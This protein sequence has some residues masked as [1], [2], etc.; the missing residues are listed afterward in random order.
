MLSGSRTRAG[1]LAKDLQEHEL[2]AFTV[3][4]MTGDLNQGRL[5]GSMAMQKGFEYPL[6]KFAVITETIFSDRS[7]KKEKKKSTTASGFRIL[8]SC[9][10]GF[11]CP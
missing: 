10:S 1:R 6:I 8:Q 2:N 7:R 4:I 5:W 3:K 11:C 9:L